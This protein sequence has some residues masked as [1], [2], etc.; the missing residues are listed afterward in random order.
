M[1]S[2]ARIQFVRGDGVHGLLP[3]RRWGRGRRRGGE[4]GRCAGSPRLDRA[5]RRRRGA[6]GR[7]P[8]GLGHGRAGTPHPR[9]SGRRP[10][11]RRS[12]HRRE[13]LLAPPEPRSGGGGGRGLRRTPDAAASPRPAVAAPP[14]GPPPGATRRRR[15]GARDHQR[16]EPRRAGDPRDR[17]HDDLQRLRPGSASGRPGGRAHRP[18]RPRCRTLAAATDAR[19]GAQEHRGS[20]RPGRGARRHLLAPRSGRGRVRTRTRAPG[21]A[22]PLPRGP[23]PG[24]GR[25]LHRRCLRRL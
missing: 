8:P 3:A 5:E 10:R 24:H 7:R 14:P 22:R 23:R 17:G 1:R 12:G 4:M 21:R 25:L 18:R 19:T 15:M 16:A 11:R 9:R 6:G 13:P 2:S 20:H